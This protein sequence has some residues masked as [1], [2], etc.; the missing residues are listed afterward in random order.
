VE[1]TEGTGSCFRVFL[2]ASGHVKT[3]PEAPIGA[4]S[5]GGTETILVV[6]DESAVRQLARR[7]LTSKGYTVVEATNGGE[8]LELLRERH[9]EIDLV[10]S[11][12][13]MPVLGG[14]TLSAEMRRLGFR[15]PMVFMSGYTDNSEPLKDPFGGVAPFVAKPFT[16]ATLL[17]N[18]R[19]ALDRAEPQPM[20]RKT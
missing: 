6:E 14:R 10:L 4:T 1:S 5:S 2:P 18:V 17:E 15:I 13:V 20:A 3:P 16:A 7:L 9:E 11:D 19:Q 8:A 12:V